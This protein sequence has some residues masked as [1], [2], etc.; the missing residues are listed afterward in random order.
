MHADRRQ[1]LVFVG[2]TGVGAAFAQSPESR[3]ERK[4]SPAPDDAIVLRQAW[5][6]ALSLGKPLL[7]LVIPNRRVQ[8]SVADSMGALLTH[9]TDET[10][11]TLALAELV[12]ANRDKIR[13]V[14]DVDVS[15]TV[16]YALIDRVGESNV[17]QA[18]GI[19]A[20]TKEP[21]ASCLKLD[22][23]L[24]NQRRSGRS[25]VERLGAELTAALAADAAM[26]DQRAARARERAP[27]ALRDAV[28]GDTPHAGSVEKLVDA[29]ALV[30]ARAATSPDRATLI[31]RLAEGV[32]KRWANAPPPGSYWAENDGCGMTLPDVP[33]DQQ[34]AVLCGMGDVS[35]LSARFLWFYSSDYRTW[36]REL[37]ALDR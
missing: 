27:Q 32:R 15:V 3:P 21:A 29:A 35:V 5:E 28:A 17:V 37:E 19:N 34:L 10:L 22:R 23:E 18:S 26:I 9:G 8:P 16:G 24:L 13:R 36:M 6:R 14:L 33:E 30:H 7:V 20:G 12:C 25:A 1:F 4:G 31:A 11:A 2:A